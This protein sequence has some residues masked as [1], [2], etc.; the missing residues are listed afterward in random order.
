TSNQDFMTC[1]VLLVAIQ[2][3]RVWRDL[4]AE[5]RRATELESRLAEARLD[6]LRMQLHPHFLFNPLHAVTGLIGEDPKTARRMV[7]A[8]GDLLRRT[9]DEPSAPVR[10]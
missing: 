7:V 9:L 10:G 6:A 5:Q 8:L 2:A 1:V 4:E 3:W